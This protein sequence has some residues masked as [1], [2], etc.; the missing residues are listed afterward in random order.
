MAQV[1]G[2]SL[3]QKTGLLAFCLF[4]IIATMASGL[5]AWTLYGRM[6]EEFV[7]K[8]SAIASSIA[9]GSQEILLA[10]DASTIQSMID[11]YLAID[12]VAYVFVKDADHLV[13]AHTFV[14]EMPPELRE[15][16]H[17]KVGEVRELEIEG[18]GRV[19]DICNPVLAGVGRWGP[20]RHG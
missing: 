14:P 11:Q 20:C 1:R 4:G 16:K 2:L 3:F 5:A 9:R 6:T 13:V 15:W 18:V 17:H 7:S 8:G 19:I 12:G 10:R